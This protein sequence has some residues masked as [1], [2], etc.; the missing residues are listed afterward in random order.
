[1]TGDTGSVWVSVCGIA[2]VVA[3]L[4]ILAGFLAVRVLRMSIFGLGMMAL[5]VI[6]DPKPESSALDTRRAAPLPSSR[7]LRA[8]AQSLDF[9]EAVARRR[10]N[11][12]APPPPVSSM[13]AASAQAAPPEPQPRLRRRRRGNEEDD[14]GLLAGFMDDDGS[15]GIL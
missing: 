1:M 11:P 3:F 4:I 8:Q 9:D 2:A 12:N 15:G 14:D 13:P 6:T 5:R 10:S 7:D